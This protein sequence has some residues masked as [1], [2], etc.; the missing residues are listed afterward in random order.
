M[1]D[2]EIGIWQAAALASPFG[3]GA[4]VGGGEGPLSHGLSRDSSPIG[5]AK[6]FPGI[7]QI[8][9]YLSAAFGGYI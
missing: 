5:G 2:R 9:I 1:T 3:R 8:L 4:P 6:V 7:R